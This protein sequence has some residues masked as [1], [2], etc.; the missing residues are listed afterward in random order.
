MSKQATHGSLMAWNSL[1][2]AVP[3]T[4]SCAKGSQPCA[5][6]L[7]SAMANPERKSIPVRFLRSLPTSP[8]YDFMWWPMAHIGQGNGEGGKA[9]TRV[10]SARVRANDAIPWQE[11][12]EKDAYLNRA[13]TLWGNPKARGALHHQASSPFPDARFRDRWIQATELWVTHLLPSFVVMAVCSKCK[14]TAQKKHLKLEDQ[15]ESKETRCFLRMMQCSDPWR[16]R[17]SR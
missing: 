1:G 8:L 6:P 5:P 7:C 17:K 15:Q 12:T 4:L 13:E 10:P 11:G 3:L 2:P 9:N 16:K 14:V